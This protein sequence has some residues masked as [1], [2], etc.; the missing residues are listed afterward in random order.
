M[1]R[2]GAL[3]AGA[4]RASGERA[5]RRST[6][7]I[8]AEPVTVADDTASASPPSGPASTARQAS[9]SSA[10]GTARPAKA[11]AGRTK[12]AAARTAGTRTAAP[13]AAAAPPP[14]APAR[15]PAPSAS[16]GK[17]PG[18]G[19]GEVRRR[20]HRPAPT[21]TSAPSRKVASVSGE[22]PRVRKVSVR[23]K[24]LRDDAA[25]RRAHLRLAEPPPVDPTASEVATR[26]GLPVP[27]AAEIVEA[28]VT[29]LRVAAGAA[30]VS[31]EDVERRIAQVLAYLRRRVDGD[32]LVDDFGYDEDFTTNVFYPVLRPLYRHWFRVEVR[33]IENIP[34]TGGA[35]V[36]S[37]HSGTV[38]YDSVM[39]QLAIHD[40]HPRHRLMRALGADFVFRTP[41]IG[42]IARRSGS[43]LATASDAERLLGA[44]ELVGVFPEGF[45]GIGKPFSERYKLQR[46]GRG[47][48]VS[49]A[50]RTGVPIIPCSVV[51]AEEIAPIIGNMD[52]VARLLGLPY[53]P[54]T[55]TWP[56]LGPLGM[57]PLPSKW[58]IEFGAPIH[59]DRHEPGAADD[60]MLVFDLTDQV[61]E[62]IQQ[63]LYTLLMQRRSVFF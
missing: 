46:F 54:V 62:T 15:P 45:K 36:V 47:G 59:T 24:A 14:P 57:V 23:E 51:G 5:R 10:K 35:L 56:L 7:L 17:A 9:R 61:R 43:T 11:A 38:A 3:A 19:A 25:A 31:P 60:P 50:L 8:G 1:A 16:P 49:A 40:E 33:G 41:F 26:G 13:S 27:D 4:A 28:L 63:T 39:I 44:G 18:P 29:G 37:N 42:T 21:V 30:G 34:E 48:F 52:T 53:M 20:P 12:A 22:R 58:I 2:Q 55:P 32:Y 6:P